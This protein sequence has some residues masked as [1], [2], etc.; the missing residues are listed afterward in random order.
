MQKV[1]VVRAMAMRFHSKTSSFVP[2]L[3]KWEIK[4]P[5][6]SGS[7]RDLMPVLASVKRRDSGMAF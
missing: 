1:C 5:V 7:K 6:L 2:T 4:G 3:V